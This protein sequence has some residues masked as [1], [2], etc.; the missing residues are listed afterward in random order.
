MALSVAAWAQDSSGN[1]LNRVN[2]TDALKNINQNGRDDDVRIG[3]PEAE[4]I[5]KRQLEY[6]KKGYQEHL[7]RA[8]EIS[9]LGAGLHASFLRK[10]SLDKEDYRKLERVEKLAKRVRE[11]MSDE[12]D[13]AQLEQAPP[14]LEAAM[15]QLD[16][17]AQE[18]EK[19]VAATPRLVISAAVIEQAAQ[20]EAL[21][22]YIRER[23]AVNAK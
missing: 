17:D 10:K 13:A 18:L 12:S 7:A 19:K 4:M 1:N 14:T 21:A 3:T 20:L 9:Q 23:W 16:K 22:R 15:L 11:K 8:K 5:R 2:K 6:D